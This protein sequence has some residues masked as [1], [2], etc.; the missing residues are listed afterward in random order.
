MG[1]PYAGAVTDVEFTHD[2]RLISSG[3]TGLRLWDLEEGTSELLLPCREKHY[4][5]FSVSADR[6][7]VL[8][9]DLDLTQELPS[10]L[11][12][13]DLEAGISREIT[14]HGNRMFAAALDPSGELVATGDFDGIVRVGPVTG[15]EPH[16]LFGHRPGLQVSSVAISPDGR[17]VASASQDGTIRI[18]PMPEGQPF[19]TLPHE[20]LLERLRALTNLRVV[21]DADAE[22]G[23][24][25]SVGPFPGWRTA[26]T[27]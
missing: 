9:W 21:A 17:H 13:L 1:E 27:W 11:T 25:L 26:P 22:T 14:S 3:T 2:G 5:M 18:W 16:L 20:E 24:E 12:F 15:E 8:A 7:R 4:R 19:H 23:Y 6:R 10:A